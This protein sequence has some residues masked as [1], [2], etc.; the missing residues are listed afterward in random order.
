MK[1]KDH[2]VPSQ[3]PVVSLCLSITYQNGRVPSQHPA[4][5]ENRTCFYVTRSQHDYWYGMATY[6][7][8]RW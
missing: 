4:E 5:P 7:M 8:L 3:H 6:V 2:R 1:N